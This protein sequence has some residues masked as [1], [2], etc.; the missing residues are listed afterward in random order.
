MTEHRKAFETILRETH[1]ALRSY[2]R[3][4]GVP[5]AHVDDIAQET[6]LRFYHDRDALPEG[7]EPIRWLK[8]VARNLVLMHFRRHYTHHQA[9]EKL[10]AE[11][12][13]ESTPLEILV[14]DEQ[15]RRLQ[16]AVN[17]CIG[18]LSE[19]N[20]RLLLLHHRDGRPLVDI[21]RTLGQGAAAV[22]MR[23]VRIRRFLR[24]CIEQHL[25]A[26]AGA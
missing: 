2:I 21:S 20:R 26:R 6:Y 19:K 3:A 22:R 1:V 25:E 7:V 8:G 18:R 23:M 5:A 16:D 24:A 10:G 15:R 12:A 13:A 17:D 4:R 14:E 11:E 9:V